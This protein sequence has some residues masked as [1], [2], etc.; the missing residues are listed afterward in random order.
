MTTK[1]RRLLDFSGAILEDIEDII[2]PVIDRARDAA[3]KAEE[4]K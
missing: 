4:G 3:E 2:S 1:T